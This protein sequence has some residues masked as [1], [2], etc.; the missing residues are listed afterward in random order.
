MTGPTPHAVQPDRNSEWT[1]N[2]APAGARIWRIL[3][4]LH[5]IYSFLLFP[6]EVRL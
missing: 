4:V 2:E 1:A 6:V 3:P 5:L